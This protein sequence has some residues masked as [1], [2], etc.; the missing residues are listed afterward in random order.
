MKAVVF[1][2]L[3]AVAAARPQ[4]M[5]PQ[6]PIVTY[7]SVDVDNAKV[8][9]SPLTYTMPSTFPLTYSHFPYTYPFINPLVAN[10]AIKVEAESKRTKR[11]A[12]PE[13]EPE[14]DPLTIYSGLPTLPIA[15]TTTYPTY[16]TVS[17]YGSFPFTYAT[18]PQWPYSQWSSVIK[19][20]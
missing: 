4:F 20:V 2:A 11:D 7:K 8:I 19:T 6:A 1:L 18:Y 13:P 17:T 14:A 10:P 3:L 5:F 15:G 9:T 16:P 12:D